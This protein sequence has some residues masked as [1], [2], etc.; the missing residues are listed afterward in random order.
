MRLDV[1]AGPSLLPK[2]PLNL[3]TGV[4]PVSDVPGGPYDVAKYN[5]TLDACIIRYANA[6]RACYGVSCQECADGLDTVAA[7]C[8]QSPTCP[9]ALTVDGRHYLD[10]FHAYRFNAVAQQC[11]HSID[12]GSSYDVVQDVQCGAPS[13]DGGPTRSPV[14]SAPPPRPFPLFFRRRACGTKCSRSLLED[15][16][17]P[18]VFLPC[19]SLAPSPRPRS[20]LAPSLVRCTALDSHRLRVRLAVSSRPALSA[21]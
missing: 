8:V 3:F 9:L 4:T 13:P 12:Q 15:F 18:F 7:D 6:R 20:A 11:M 21:S 14:R 5:A 19:S 1:G 2:L 17:R 16:P 10:V